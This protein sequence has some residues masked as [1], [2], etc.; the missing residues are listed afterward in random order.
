MPCFI[1]FSNDFQAKLTVYA[2]DVHQVDGEGILVRRRDAFFV[3]T[4]SFLQC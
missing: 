2:I 4:A 1:S 3:A